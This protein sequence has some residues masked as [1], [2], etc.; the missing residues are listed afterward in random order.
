MVLVSAGHSHSSL[1]VVN[2]RTHSTAPT[3]PPHSTRSPSRLAAPSTQVCFRWK[4]DWEWGLHHLARDCIVATARHQQGGQPPGAVHHRVRQPDVSEEGGRCYRPVPNSCQCFVC[5]LHSFSSLVD[6][7]LCKSGV[8]QSVYCDRTQ[9]RFCK[10][11]LHPC[12][13]ATVLAHPHDIWCPRLNLSRSVHVDLQVRSEFEPQ[14]LV[15]L[16]FCHLRE[17]LSPSA[18]LPIPCWHVDVQGALRVPLSSTEPRPLWSCLFSPTRTTDYSPA[19]HYHLLFCINIQIPHHRPAQPSNNTQTHREEVKQQHNSGEQTTPSRTNTNRLLPHT[20]REEN[21][22]TTHRVRRRKRRRKGGKEKRKQFQAQNYHNPKNQPTP[23]RTTPP[24][25]P[26]HINTL[27]HNVT[28]SSISNIHKH[29]QTHTSHN[30]QDSNTKQT[31][32]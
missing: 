27:S 19:C 18:G 1:F 30:A 24:D 13:E 12:R 16:L 3:P 14:V 26:I 17:P 31:Y 29:S 5:L 15:R 11:H 2:H 4:A 23:T 10:D 6:L 9:V 22:K 7:A 32:V 25:R 20:N 21:N 8:F 28:V